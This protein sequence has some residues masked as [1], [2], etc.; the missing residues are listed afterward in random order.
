MFQLQKINLSSKEAFSNLI[1][2]YDTIYGKMVNARELHFALGVKKKF[3]D[4]IKH[5]MK[6]YNGYEYGFSTIQ[7]D[8]PEEYDYFTYEVK[9]TQKR[10][11]SK[12]YILSL[13]VAKEISMMTKGIIGKEVRKYFI[14][15]EKVLLQLQLTNLEHE[16]RDKEKIA[17]ALLISESLLKNKDKELKNALRSKVYNKKVNMELRRQIKKLKDINNKGINVDIQEIN[18]TMKDK[19][20]EIEYLENSVERLED[21][22]AQL[23][24]RINHLIKIKVDGKAILNA[25]AN[26]DIARRQRLIIGDEA[27]K[28]A[29][30]KA[31]VF[32]KES[33]LNAGIILNDDD[34]QNFVNNIAIEDMPKAIEAYMD[35]LRKTINNTELFEEL[36]ENQLKKINTFMNN[37]NIENECEEELQMQ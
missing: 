2:I 8:N 25:V 24:A 10:G 14:K 3:S 28:K 23:K 33:I 32:R 5:H 7:P 11:K 20:D 34:K 31:Y 13:D 36:F 17:E 16:N 6:D 9:A 15:T 19:N 12:E 27:K 26:V 30:I 4:W 35:A 29:K 37:I 22:N 1:P 21:Q 18:K